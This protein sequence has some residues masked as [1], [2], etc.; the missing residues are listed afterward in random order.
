MKAK[1]KGGNKFKKMKKGFGEVIT[2][3]EIA[4][5]FQNYAQ[6][7][8]MLGDGRVKIKCII[9]DKI[10]DKLGIIRGSMRKRQWINSGDIIIVSIRDFEPNKCDVI[11]VY[12][13]ERRNEIIKKANLQFNDKQV[14]INYDD[15]EFYNS[16]D[17]EEDNQQITHFQ[18]EQ[19]L[20]SNH[21]QFTQKPWFLDNEYQSDSDEEKENIKKNIK[22]NLDNDSEDNNKI[23]DDFINNI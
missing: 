7:I 22:F 20:S 2:K 23:D 13:K 4:D 5:K 14:S 21:L 3:L 12:P 10:V 15:V 16:E 1:S 9:N 18:K 19:D 11:Y 6:V 8:S 17:D